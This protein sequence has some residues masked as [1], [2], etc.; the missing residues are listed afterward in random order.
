MLKVYVLLSQCVCVW[1]MYEPSPGL[2]TRSGS[3]TLGA[4][5]GVLGG[6]HLW[7]PPH[8]LHGQVWS[9]WSGGCLWD[10]PFSL[11]TKEVLCAFDVKA[12][13]HDLKS[14]RNNQLNMVDYSSEI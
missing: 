4:P 13:L 3:E 2:R 9:C 14:K 8:C 10:L 6:P 11:L 12:R 5:L 1:G 7:S